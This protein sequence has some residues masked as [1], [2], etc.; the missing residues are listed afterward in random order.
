[1]KCTIGDVDLDGSFPAWGCLCVLGSLLLRASKAKS[2]PS[3]F[4]C[5]SNSFFVHGMFA[6]TLIQISL[7]VDGMFAVMLIQ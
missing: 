1:M 7:Q 4:I 6:V 3:A 5:S 2:F